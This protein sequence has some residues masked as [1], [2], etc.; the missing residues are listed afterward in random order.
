M[1]NV[2]VK[3]MQLG[4]IYVSSPSLLGTKVEGWRCTYLYL[5]RNVNTK[6]FVYLFIG[7]LNGKNRYNEKEIYDLIN[8]YG[9][10]S[11]HSNFEITKSNKKLYKMQTFKD[12]NDFKFDINSPYLSN[13]IRSS[14]NFWLNEVHY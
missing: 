6:Q 8:L 5:G 9:D 12:F 13:I 10:G 14:I 7:T 2:K 3:D 11:F 1:E 4:H